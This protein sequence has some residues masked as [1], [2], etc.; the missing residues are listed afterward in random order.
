MAN[1]DPFS[2]QNPGPTGPY[3]NGFAVTPSDAPNGDFEVPARALWIGTGGTLRVTLRGGDIVNLTNIA[4][5]T[6]LPLWTKRVHVTG[7]G[8]SNIVALY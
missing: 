4:N 3:T 8:A 1:N 5:G 7:T 2:G 6:L